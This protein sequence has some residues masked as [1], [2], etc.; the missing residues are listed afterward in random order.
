MAVYKHVASRN[1]AADHTRHGVSGMRKPYR[2]GE[3]EGAQYTHNA[4]SDSMK[5][6][7]TQSSH[8]GNWSSEHN[9]DHTLRI[10]A[11][12][13]GDCAFVTRIGLQ[14][15]NI[16]HRPGQVASDNT[17]SVIDAVKEFGQQLLQLTQTVATP[18][19][20]FLRDEICNYSAVYQTI[21]DGQA[22]NVD[23][24]F[25][26]WTSRS[27][28]INANTNNYHDWENECQGWC[29]IVVLGDF[30]VGDACFPELG[31][32]IDCTPGM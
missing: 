17:K 22:D 21:C 30:E 20:T 9:P 29:A 15:P 1:I 27:F 18:F 8:A 4:T 12:V 24:G 10:K 14:T 7:R 28:V 11:S 13:I 26:I 25:G 16:G 23:Q 3:M 6:A 19:Q 5:D 2:P 32:M 31:V